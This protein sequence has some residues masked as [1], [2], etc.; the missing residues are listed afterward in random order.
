VQIW[1]YPYGNPAVYSNMSDAVYDNPAVYGNMWDT[2]YDNPAVYG[3]MWVDRRQAWILFENCLVLNSI[4]PERPLYLLPKPLLRKK[5]I[6]SNMYISE[7][8]RK[9]MSANVKVKKAF[10]FSFFFYRCRHYSCC[11]LD[12]RKYKK[13]E[14]Q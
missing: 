6:A 8:G 7:V 4:N 11:H 14:N 12:I 13:R 5:K 3:N 1:R 2:V 9:E 10:F